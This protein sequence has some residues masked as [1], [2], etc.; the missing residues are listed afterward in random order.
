MVELA[1]SGGGAD[2]VFP[3]FSVSG[4]RHAVWTGAE[5]A[6]ARAN[7]MVLEA[8]RRMNVK[9]RYVHYVHTSWMVWARPNGRKYEVIMDS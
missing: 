9:M 1:S 6:P 8:S 4:G 5:L 3:R 7:E 2:L